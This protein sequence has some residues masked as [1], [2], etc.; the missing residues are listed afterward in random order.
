[1]LSTKTKKITKRTYNP[2][3][4]VPQSK[5]QKMRSKIDKNSILTA[6][7]K[8]CHI[9]GFDNQET[10]TTVKGEIQSTPNYPPHHCLVINCKMNPS[11][12][13]QYEVSIV[14]LDNIIVFIVKNYEKYFL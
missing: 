12:D 14:S 8:S 7:G 9:K 1:M 10:S 2:E 13:H 5:R 4:M 11:L 3:A 6:Y